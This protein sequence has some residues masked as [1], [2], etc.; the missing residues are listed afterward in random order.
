MERW[1]AVEQWLIAAPIWLQ[2]VVLL[3][4]LI[5]LLTVVA[6]ILIRIIDI[7]VG[8]AHSR[9]AQPG[10]VVEAEHAEHKEQKES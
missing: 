3:I 5:P 7:A 10:F 9:W 4:V 6:F 1:D 2:S 8:M